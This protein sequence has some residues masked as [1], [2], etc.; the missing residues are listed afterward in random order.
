MEITNILMSHEV[1]IRRKP[2]ATAYFKKNVESIDEGSW[3]IGA[4]I[5]HNSYLK[6]LTFEEEAKLL[7]GIIQVKPESEHWEAAVKNYW[8]NISVKVPEAGLKLE[9]G[10]KYK[11][12]DDANRKENGIP[13]NVN[14]Y[15]LYRYCLEYSHVANTIDL[16]GASPNI[17]FYI[18][19][20]NEEKK[21]KVS[22]LKVRNEAMKKYLDILG[23]RGLVDDILSIYKFDTSK[24]EE[25]DKDIIL[26][27][28][29]NDRPESFLAII[30]DEILKYKSFV[31]KCLQRGKLSQIP[32]TEVILFGTDPI[33]QNITEAA[34]FLKSS[35]PANI[36]VYD[37]LVAQLGLLT[38]KEVT[39][40]IK[41]EVKD[42]VKKDEKKKVDLNIPFD[43]LN[44]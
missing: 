7:P 21:A 29:V 9:V 39:K 30:K 11:N 14:D 37:T 19:D 23:D 12:K 38:S 41:E 5:R 44:P 2:I 20:K 4:S 24:M 16:V 27:T 28:Q 10:L 32:N 15:I 25:D 42:E 35:H 34:V 22:Q 36:K 26:E 13:I 43:P 18:Y 6:G 3:K 1:E 17:R 40:E 8:N 31:N 33:G